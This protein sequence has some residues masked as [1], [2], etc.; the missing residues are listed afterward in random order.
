MENKQSPYLLLFLCST[1]PFWGNLY[2][3][4]P[5]SPLPFF[6][7][8]LLLSKAFTL[9]APFCFWKALSLPQG[10]KYF[11]Q[12]L[13]LQNNKIRKFIVGALV[14]IIMGASIIASFEI[15]PEALQK[16]TLSRIAL[17]IE[18][19]HI[20][21]TFWLYAVLLSF[22]HSLLEEFYWR[23]F[24]FAAFK[25]H[26]PRFR[27]FLVALAFSLHHF[28]VTIFYFDFKLGF[29]LGWGVFVAG[30]IWTKLYE[31]E[32][33]LGA[34]WISHIIADIALMSFGFRALSNL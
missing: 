23:F 19:L 15:L 18:T 10:W 31:K 1:L 12:H 11:A 3:F 20:R 24:L 4:L 6:E 26:L 22:A 17:K 13:D 25:K 14:G 30:Y 2:S 33:S 34:V 28:V 7:A 21:K 32:N 16:E 8:I 9:I 27:H 5:K 29:I